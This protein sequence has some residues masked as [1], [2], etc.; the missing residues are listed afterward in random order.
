[1]VIFLVLFSYGVLN[2]NLDKWFSRP[3]RGIE[4][5]LTDTAVALGDEVQSRADALAK[6]LSTAPEVRNGTADFGKL[7]RENRIAEL[8]LDDANAEGHIFCN[9]E[10]G[11]QLFTARAPM[12]EQG[13]L[14]VRV[15]PRVDLA[16]K[17]RTIEGFVREY[18]Q[19]SS[20]RRQ[21]RSLYL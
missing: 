13:T 12:A 14:V 17:Q 9:S 7:C 11:G 10:G 18:D 21:I 1:P 6:W 8:R 5:Q 3:G 15:A 20:R 19:L 2:R 4:L 16:Q